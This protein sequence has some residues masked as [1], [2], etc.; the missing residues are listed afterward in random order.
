MVMKSYRT[1]KVCFSISLSQ[2]Y[3]IPLTDFRHVLK[4]RLLAEDIITGPVDTFEGEKINLKKE[5]DKVQVEFTGANGANT[6]ATVL[7]PSINAK[8]GIIHKIDTIL[9]EPTT[10]TPTDDLIQVLTKKGNFK[11]LIKAITADLELTE[12]INSADEKTI[13]APNDAA[14]D[15]LTDEDFEKKTETEKKAIISR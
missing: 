4:K 15:K 12:K 8:N 13:F 14:F 3:W 7:K 5:V 9:L 1:P 2:F 10:P 6:T 11:Q